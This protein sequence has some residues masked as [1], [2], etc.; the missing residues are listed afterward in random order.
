MTI[1]IPRLEQ[2]LESIGFKKTNVH[3]IFIAVP[4]FDDEGDDYEQHCTEELSRLRRL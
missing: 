3:R 1:R 2:D 4:D